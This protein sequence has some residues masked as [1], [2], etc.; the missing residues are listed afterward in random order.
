[1][2]RLVTLLAIQLNLSSHE[3][4]NGLWDIFS[5]C[6]NIKIDLTPYAMLRRQITWGVAELC[7]RV[8]NNPALYSGGP[9]FKS[10]LEERPVEALVVIL[11]P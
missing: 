9:Y 3:Q 11:S 2:L 5:S 6:I 1:M 7:C 4:I 10:W 8:I